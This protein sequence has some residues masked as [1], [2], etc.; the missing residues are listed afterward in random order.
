MEPVPRNQVVTLYSL[1]VSAP[2][3]SREAKVALTDIFVAVPA[4]RRERPQLHRDPVGLPARRQQVHLRWR[5]RHR[6]Y[7][8]GTHCRLNHWRIC[9]L[10]TRRKPSQTPPF[11][12]YFQQLPNF[13]LYLHPRS[14][15]PP[16]WTA[17]H[18]NRAI[19]GLCI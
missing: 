18:L 5:K 4:S 3:E 2:C 9:D 14:C 6:Y 12:S 13:L 19:V 11:P 1:G 10:E 15:D 7:A 8:M 16:T 17:T